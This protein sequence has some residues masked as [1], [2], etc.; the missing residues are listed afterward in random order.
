M[1]QFFFFLE[2]LKSVFFALKLLEETKTN[3]CACA[4]FVSKKMLDKTSVPCRE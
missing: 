4:K 2:A 3:I 1:S